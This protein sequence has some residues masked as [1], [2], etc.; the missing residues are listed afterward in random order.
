MLKK[1]P[2]NY[3]IY[4]LGIPW[5][6]DI[7]VITCKLLKDKKRNVILKITTLVQEVCPLKT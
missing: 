5:E 6:I 1:I 3:E 4:F 2:E 7:G